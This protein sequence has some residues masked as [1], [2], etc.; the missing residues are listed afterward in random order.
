M[1]FFIFELGGIIKTRFKLSNTAFDKMILEKV[2]KNGIIEEI[3]VIGSL[4][5]TS[6]T[7]NLEEH[8]TDKVVKW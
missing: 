4:K 7:P 6:I 5:P 2:D 1:K 8:T 3:S